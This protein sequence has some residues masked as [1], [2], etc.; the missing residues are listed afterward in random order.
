[1]SAAAAALG[2]A[3]VFAGAT[4]AGVALHL[5]TPVVRRVAR[6]A[7]NRLLGSLFHGRIV[8]DEID[9]LGLD[10]VR[11]RAAVALDPG[12]KQ[13]IRA[14]GVEARADVL[15]ML[16]G[17]LFGVGPLRVEVPYIRVEQAE[18]LVEQSAAG[19]VTLGDTFTPLPPS[20]PPPAAPREPPREVVVALSRIEIGRG[21]V[22]G[23]LAP[24]RALDA[25]VSRLVGSVHVG[26]QGV[27][28]DVEQ[29][30]LVDRAFLPA[31]TAGTANYHL[32][33]GDTV[34]MWSAFAGRLA[35]VEV[36]ARAVLDE[37]HLEAHASVP[38]VTPEQLRSLVPDH[39]LTEP[40]AVRVA[41]DGDLPRLDVRASIAADPPGPAGGT[42]AVAGR[43]DVT[44]PVRLD[45]DVDAR[46]VDLRLLGVHLPAAAAPVK[47]AAAPVKTAAAPVK[48]AAAP[49]GAPAAAAPVISAEG[50][51]RVELGDELRLAV[52]ARTSPTELL[53]EQVPAADVHLV[54][55]RGELHARAHLHEPGAPIDAAISLLPRGEGIRFAATADIPAIAAAPRLAGA[56]DGAGRVRVEGTLRGETL[57]ARVEGAFAG[58]RAGPDLG[59]ASARITGR[60]SGPLDALA[61]NASL[62]GEEALAGG[63][64]FDEVTAQ[65]SGPLAAPSLRAALTDGD[66]ALSAS[67][68]LSAAT[69]ALREVELR[70]KHEGAEVTGK[71]AAISPSAGGVAVEGIELVSSELGALKG[72][73]SVRG[74]DV[75]GRLEGKSIDLGRVARVL[76]IP[77]RVRGIAD[78][79]VALAHHPRTGRSGHVQLD[80]KGGEVEFLSGV[81]AR[82]TATID[83]DQVKADGLVSITAEPPRTPGAPAEPWALPRCAGP[84]ASV[85]LSGA[86]GTL[87]GPLLRPATW[88]GLVGTAEVAADDWDLRCLA[89]LMPIGRFVSEVHGKLTTRFRISRAPGEPFPS[90]H[91]VLVRTQDLA[92][93][94]PH[95]LGAERPAWESRSI[96]AQLKG[97]LDGATGKATAALTLYDGGLLGD[98]SGSIDLDLAAL[99][100]PSAGRWASL[101]GSPIAANVAIPRRPFSAFA[102]LPSFVRDVLPPLGGELRVDAYASGTVARPR[103]LARTLWSGFTYAPGDAR[104]AADF[105]FP[106]DL[107]VW[108]TYDSEKA[109]LRAH[110]ARGADEIATV[111]ADVVAPLDRLLSPP[112]PRALKG[113]RP[114]PA[115]TGAF[116]ATLRRVPLGEIPLLGDSGIGGY[117]S[118]EVAMRDLNVA[119]KLTARLTLPGL[120][121]GDGVVFERGALS[122]RVDPSTE[123]G[124]GDLHV[125]ELVL[126]GKE[127]G[128]LRASARASV[129][130]RDG[131]LPVP[132]GERAE[133][134]ASAERFRLAALH[135]LVSQLLSKIDGLL[136]GDV[137]VDLGS[138]PAGGSLRAQL[139]VRDG[140]VHIPEFGQELRDVAAR[141]TAE[142][143]VVRIEGVRAAG[144][145]GLAQGWA[146][147]RLDGLELRDGAG[148]LTIAEDQAL[149]LT[150]EGV[151]LGTASGALT[152]IAQK[153]PGELEVHATVPT[154]RL[155]LPATSGRDVQPLGDNPDI[156]L[157]HP[158]GPEKQRRARDALRYAMTFDVDNAI[159]TGAGIRLLLSSAEDAPP[160]VVI[161]EDVRVSGGIVLAHGELEIFGKA[162]EIE[163]GRVRLREEETSNPHLNVTARWDAPDG[164]RIYADYIGNL[165]PITDK[166]LRFRSSPPSSQQ[167]ILARL[168]F[169]ADFSDG[170][171]PAGAQTSALQAAGGV[172]ASVGSELAAAQ[173][174]ALLSGIAP[175]RGLSTRFGTT[176]D[177]TLRTSLVYRLNDDLTA[178]ATFQESTAPSAATGT[179]GAT[180]LPP[181][182]AAGDSGTRTEI[183]IDWRFDR[184]WTLRGTLGL[185]ERDTTSGVIDL[186]WQYRY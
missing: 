176:S 40:I 94:G 156:S 173:F 109:T 84:I 153:K 145:T 117:V 31:T 87:R 151:P 78:V 138:G 75:T 58:L 49:G 144:M 106:A 76:G 86:E 64:T 155:S 170:A 161:G 134:T 91:D 182:G 56:V 98:A 14:S 52:E 154:L 120:S 48:T 158:L 6:D 93:A 123:P 35:D 101:L 9:A 122:L 5:D 1:M 16:G 183:T 2:L 111:N 102:T 81:S 152:F 68:R 131:I 147:F 103:L 82:L 59:L 143:G 11:I 113:A 169:G 20:R 112:S 165:R 8:A 34:R 38:R 140:V 178:Q 132:D 53:G 90:L 41:A 51:V 127:G 27:A 96:D 177:G 110:V 174:N 67:A 105:A 141:I 114:P 55:D 28:V 47:T 73:L 43:L 186:L 74:D 149:P 137:H 57:D 19:G 15:A 146:L 107:D 181:G 72:R 46:D 172:A 63:R 33:A 65:I 126:E 185:D 45:A 159:V 133:L 175:L 104:T 25:D 99:T 160:R 60:V 39:P 37:D 18:V 30:G 4:A 139:E 119:P 62:S 32:R 167:D 97:A 12:G 171:Q 17:A 44:G 24:P 77:L 118:G 184:H 179:S 135:P 163:R 21:W 95:P 23:Q 80:L 3:A 70:M 79:D 83:S 121:I 108:L 150:L 42:V 166:K 50:Q 148:A 136:D 26:P 71:I 92:L 66:G 128:A 89:Q 130:F 36:T 7:T 61:L 124:R 88:A 85:R 22:H 115:W 100:G 168:L 29:T 129:R 54:L 164:T 162:F 142:D 13:V 10:G 125:S 180:G 157:S 116:R 69:G